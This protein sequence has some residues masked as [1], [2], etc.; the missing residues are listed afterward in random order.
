MDRAVNK[1]LIANKY[2]DMRFVL[3]DI[4]HMYYI[5]EEDVVYRRRYGWV[6]YA[7]CNVPGVEEDEVTLFLAVTLIQK[8][9]Q[10]A[11]IQVLHPEPGNQRDRVWD[12]NDPDGEDLLVFYS[13]KA[14]Q[15]NSLISFKISTYL[16]VYMI[17]FLVSFSLSM[18]LTP[19][20]QQHE[21]IP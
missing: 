10:A 18:L 20:V 17:F 3:P 13:D 7:Q 4:G 1:V 5:W 14:P 21:K 15:V 6:M 11:G 2:E 19:I 16:E 8:T 9:D 12:P